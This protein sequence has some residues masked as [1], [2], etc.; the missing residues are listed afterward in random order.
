MSWKLS[1]CVYDGAGGKA[2]KDQYTCAPP[3]VLVIVIA[4]DAP[5][6]VIVIVLVFTDVSRL[7]IS[8]KVASGLLDMR[9]VVL[10][11]GDDIET[12]GRRVPGS[13]AGTKAR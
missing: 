13:A 2:A 1:V 3:V 5:L 11:W 4:A 6:I 12:M 7:A 8:A 9:D 10:A